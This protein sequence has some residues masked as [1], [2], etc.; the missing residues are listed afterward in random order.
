MTIA[1]YPVQRSLGS[2]ADTTRS[3]A[4]PLHQS[5]S[6]TDD[7]GL[8]AE[9]M[10]VPWETLCTHPHSVALA[11][12]DPK[13]TGTSDWELMIEAQIEQVPPPSDQNTNEVLPYQPRSRNQLPSRPPAED[14]LRSLTRPVASDP[15]AAPTRMAIVVS[16]P[17]GVRVISDL[18]SR[19]DRGQCLKSRTIRSSTAISLQGHAKSSGESQAGIQPYGSLTMHRNVFC[20]PLRDLCV[21][22]MDQLYRSLEAE[23]VDGFH[24]IVSPVQVGGSDH[25]V[26][27]TLRALRD[28][29]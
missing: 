2:N 16:E 12:A 6:Y 7:Q 13:D 9:H 10:I 19:G 23:G 8:F 20:R 29:T 11:C 28:N 17:K 15:H 3:P 21:P 1:L 27:F 25:P 26:Q 5:A 24:M 4:G 18:V 22:G 14:D